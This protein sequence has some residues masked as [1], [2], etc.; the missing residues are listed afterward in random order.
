MRYLILG[1]TLALDPHGTPVPLTA[2]RLRRLLAA[3]ALRPGRAVPVGVLIGDVW[4][5]DE[6]QDA[7]AA[8]QALVGRLRRVIGK[9]AV[10]SAP[11]GYRLVAAADVV[12]LYEFEGL[13]RTAADQPADTAAHTLRTALDLWRGPALADLDDPEYAARPEARRL[14]ALR[15]RIAA[16]LERGALDGLVPELRELA[17]AH[18][19]HE[20]F[21]ALLIRALAA[22]GH[23]ADAL[24]AY[25]EARRAIAEGLGADPGPELRALY[26]ELLGPPPE[27]PERG[28]LRPR[29]TSFVGRAPDIETIRADLTRSRLVTLTGPGGSGKTRLAEEAAAP[30][31][32]WLVELA[33][34]DT[35]DALPGAVLSALRLRQTTL[36]APESGSHADPAERLVAQLRDRALLLVLD[37]CEHLIEAAA[38]LTETLLTHCPRLTV[39]ATSREPLGVPGELVRPVDPL[40]GPVALR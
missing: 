37:N 16:D 12:D 34:L 22:E 7:P 13:V 6:P 24:V 29:L 27:R 28:N 9:D 38:E 40:P 35:P 14:T 3:L 21:R 15:L 17:G 23:H 5:G 19:Y 39:L 33:P 32:A 4:R 8:L 20:P 2:P 36:I 26:A 30:E 11:G 25:E 31:T 1:G 10:E 18:P